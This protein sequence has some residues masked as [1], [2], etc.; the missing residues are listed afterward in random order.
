M[1]SLLLHGK[2]LACCSNTHVFI[3]ANFA[4]LFWVFIFTDRNTKT[5][6]QGKRQVSDGF[7]DRNS[8]SPNGKRELT[9]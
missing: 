3:N 7:R 8:K 9:R 1:S 5:K 2:I 6:L 4:D